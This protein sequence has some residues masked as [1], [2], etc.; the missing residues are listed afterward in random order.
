M[1]N[2]FQLFSEYNQLMNQRLYDA[3]ARLSDEELCDDKGAFFNSVIGTLN[4]ILV[5]DIIWLK[6]FST[7]PSSQHSLSYF[8][9]IEKPES[10]GLVLYSDL[11]QLRSER[12]KIDKIVIPWIK[13]LSEG[14]I[15]GSITYDN[16][17]G[18]RLKKAICQLDKSFVSSYRLKR[19]N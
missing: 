7:H 10:L 9:G 17:N 18:K 3:S 19:D 4:P 15:I 16:M 13:S 11:G 5:G 1:L 2:Q 12:A 6:R 14:D 8:S